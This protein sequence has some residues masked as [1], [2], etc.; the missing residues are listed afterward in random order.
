M[1]T[2]MSCVD[3]RAPRL[4]A[5]AMAFCRTTLETIF[6]LI[7]DTTNAVASEIGNGSVNAHVGNQRC[8]HACMV[9]QKM[10][11]TCDAK[12]T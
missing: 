12:D 3:L 7:S 11:S 8:V 9:E 4:N 6:H 1:C 5:I 2:D 10:K